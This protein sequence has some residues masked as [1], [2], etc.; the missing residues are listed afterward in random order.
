MPFIAVGGSI[1]FADEK[2]Q[3]NPFSISAGNNGHDSFRFNTG[4]TIDFFNSF[5]IGG[6]AGFTN[7][8]SKEFC[9][10]RVPNN[11]Y[12]NMMY[13]FVTKVCYSPGNTWHTSV[14]MN[15]Y[16]YYENWS[17][18]AEYV[19]A[20]H[21]KDKISLLNPEDIRDLTIMAAGTCE[22]KGFKPQVLECKSAWSVQVI[23]TGLTWMPSP[24]ITIGA[25]AQIP[26]Q[27][28]NAYK[29]TTLAVSFELI[30]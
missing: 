21:G 22:N 16:N 15:S 18:Y 9:E 20:T 29:S 3:D 27:R 17:F 24:N 6:T 26:I 1:G 14:F 5:E 30:Y 28:R 19:W 11:D 8:K 7:F 4:F 10:F 2:N 23:N 25:N 12:Q 13:P